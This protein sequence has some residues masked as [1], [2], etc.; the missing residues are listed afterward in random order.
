MAKRKAD[1]IKKIQEEEE[2]LSKQI[3]GVDQEI[4]MI[5][6]LSEPQ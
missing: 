6:G 2:G 4:G 3:E 1:R 5:K